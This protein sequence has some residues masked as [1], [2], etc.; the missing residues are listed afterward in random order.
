MARKKD[1]IL[2]VIHYDKGLTNAMGIMPDPLLESGKA[3][4]SSIE[5]ENPQIQ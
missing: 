4:S 5:P 3:T 1:N 2:P